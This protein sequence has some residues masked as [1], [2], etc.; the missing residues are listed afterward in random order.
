MATL[1]ISPTG[2]GRMD[3]SSIE[4][5]ATLSSLNSM[6]GKAG[7]GG[8]VLL[9]ADQGAYSRTTQ[10]SIT[11]G[12]TEDAPVTIRGI[13]SAGQP[14]DAEIAGSRAPNW[15][16]GKAA[17]S[18]LFRLLD[19]ADNLVFEDLDIENIGNGAFRVGADIENLTIRSV[20]ATNVGRFIEDYKSGTATSATIDGLAVQDCTITG[21][22]SNAIRL[23]YDTHDVV[24]ENVVGDSQG[25]DGGLYISG[26]A[27]DGTAHDILISRTEMKNSAGNG[28]AGEYWNGDGFTTERGVYNVTFVDTLASGNTDAG[29]DLKSSNTQLVRAHAEGNNKNYRL[30]SDSIT[31][32]DCSSADPVHA[33]GTGVLSHIWLAS[34]AD[35]VINNLDFSDEG[36]AQL[37]FDL[38]RT[39]VTL[40]LIDTDVP[41][42]YADLIN[43]LLSKV[44]FHHSPSEITISS[45][46]VL[47]NCAGGT[48]VGALQ[49]ADQDEGDSISYAL[50]GGATDLFELV[51][52]EIRVKNGAAI[53]YEAAALHVITVTATDST[54]LTFTRDI[55]IAVGDLPD[56]VTSGADL[57]V[58]NG[59]HMAAGAG[60]DT[61]VVS[62]TADTITERAGEG[63]DTV[64]TTLAQ[65]ALGANLEN[66]AYIGTGD[67]TGVG[68]DAKNVLT[69]GAGEDLLKGGAGNDTI[70]GGAGDDELYGDGNRDEIRG[71]AGADL[72]RG[73]AYDD[74]IWGDDDNDTLFGDDG[75]DYL[76]GGNGNDLMNGGTAGDQMVGAA[77][78]DTYVVDATTDTVSEQAG[79]G[80]DKVLSAIGYTLV[81]NVEDLELTGTAAINGTGNTLANH[82]TGNQGNNLLNGGAGNDILDGG[83]GDDHLVGGTGDDTY[84]FGIGH[85]TAVGGVGDVLRFGEG[86]RIDQVWLEQHG[87]DLIVSLL[88]SDDQTVFEGWFGSDA[89]RIDRL[90]FAD[91]S[92]ISAEAATEIALSHLP[93]APSFQ[94]E[95]FPSGS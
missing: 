52:N 69:G 32:I 91:G 75:A 66:L 27:I 13:D 40:H 59:G 31:L 70:N 80:A 24:I 36:A 50:T 30:W 37:L 68:N 55:T 51:G 78:D 29:Y 58:G 71:G 16:P 35:V 28:S 46:Q 72:V 93:G 60:N 19:G 11:K 26:I 90:E 47:E 53:D 89:A 5:A 49:A 48:L 67:F 3:G 15:E 34:G 88:G 43:N 21:Y 56:T 84:V 20:D 83:A 79:Q 22:S 9:I 4:N 10:L 76:H 39:D 94:P 57:I 17:G 6:I 44:F 8:E 38:N 65:Y 42:A 1:F 64:K 74:R 2:S 92:R 87:Q 63:T 85:D 25:Q 45:S 54:G 23:Q 81:A 33:G 41:A 62:S 77:G 7:P 95:E 18:E 82:I 12:G 14:M 61:Y 86:V 73:G